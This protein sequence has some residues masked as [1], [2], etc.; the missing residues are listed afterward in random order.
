M[1]NDHNIIGAIY[2][3][4]TIRRTP[5]WTPETQPN[6]VKASFGWVSGIQLDSLEK[7]ICLARK[8]CKP[9]MVNDPSILSLHKMT[10][11]EALSLK[12]KE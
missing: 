12:L 11:Q 8:P 3:V 7:V 6:D 9:P 2:L 4:T 5:T 10:E 1:Y